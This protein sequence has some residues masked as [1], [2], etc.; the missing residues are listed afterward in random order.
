MNRIYTLI[1]LT[2]LTAALSAQPG[3][4]QRPG[5]GGQRPGGDRG[6]RPGGDDRGRGDSG[7][8]GEVR[9]EMMPQSLRMGL[10]ETLGRISTNESEA[11]LV[12]ILDYSG[13]GVEVNLID[14]MLTEIAEGEHKYSKAVLGAAKDLLMNPPELSEVP[15]RLE[16]STNGRLWE[17]IIRY[18]DATFANDAGE[19]LI[20]EGK[21]NGSALRYFREVLKGDSVP[22]L[23]QKYRE[24]EL[25]DRGKSELYGVINDYIDIHPESGQILVER[26]QAYLVKMGEEAIAKAEADAKREAEKAAREASGEGGGDSRRGGDLREMFSRGRGG[27]SRDTAVREVRRLTEGKP[28]ADGIAARRGILNGLKA[29]T[30]DADFQNMFTQVEKRLDALANPDAEGFEKNFRLSDPVR[31]K[32]DEERRKRMEELRQNF[33]NRGNRGGQPNSGN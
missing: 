18:K 21:L 10:I 9:R 29:S 24:S 3:G 32:A 16:Q 2:A 19:L 23:A 15:S 22:I 4:G 26:F 33:Q 6:Q 7:N 25:D 13:S 11:A 8:R 27:G 5:Q 1:T 28:D 31:A 14:R 12:K 17:L 20:A 30:N